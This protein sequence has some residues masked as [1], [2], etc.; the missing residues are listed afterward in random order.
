MKV[1]KPPTWE[2]PDEIEGLQIF[3]GGSIE[4]GKAK[5]W[6]TE[7]TEF[8]SDK[9]V[10]IYNPRREDWDSSWEQSFKNKN[11]RTQVMW[12]TAHLFK[13][14]IVIFYFQGDTKSPITL[15]EF[16]KMCIPA[17]LKYKKVI[18]CCEENFWRRG[19][20]EVDCY[21]F[22]IPLVNTLDELKEELS[23]IV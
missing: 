23:K 14:D 6:Q 21:M 11:F 5:D 19:N 1:F 15:N 3:L 20:I 18:V 8:L 7:I 17:K 4:M 2:K 13:S 12:E 10:I 22:D 16:G 9:Q